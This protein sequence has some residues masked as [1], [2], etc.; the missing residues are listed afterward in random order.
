LLRLSIIAPVVILSACSAEPIQ[1]KVTTYNVLCSFCGDGHFDDNPYDDWATRLPYLKDQ[2]AAH[3]ADLIGLQE[4]LYT[5]PN[6]EQSIDDEV[7]VLGGRGPVYASIYYERDPSDF[8]SS[9]DYPDATILY[10]VDRFELTRSGHFWLSPT[11][12]EAFSAGFDPDGQLPR[13]LVWAEFKIK[14]TSQSL[15]FATT[16]VDNNRPSQ[17]LSS[18]LIRSRLQEIAGELPVI[19]VGDFNSGL[20]H[21]AYLDLTQDSEYPFEDTYSLATAP[22]ATGDANLIEAYPWQRR[23]DHIFVQPSA[24]F[25]V[26]DWSIDLMTY[27]E[28]SRTPSDHRPVH[29]TLELLTDQ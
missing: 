29:T 26:K 27:A 13:L 4:L 23:I 16:H 9:M 25:E 28:G 15:V 12:D 8:R 22:I 10:K 24:R 17:E 19:L 2:L 5:G 14:E 7:E 18:P 1:L 6:P 11:P 3:D 21:P 20:E